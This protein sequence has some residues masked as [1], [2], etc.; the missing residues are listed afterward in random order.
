[1]ESGKTTSNWLKE[2]TGNTEGVERITLELEVAA[3]RLGSCTWLDTLKS[4]EEILV[5]DADETKFS[6]KNKSWFVREVI[7][8]TTTGL[9]S[10]VEDGTEF[11]C[12]YVEEKWPTSKGKQ[13][14]SCIT[15]RE[16]TI[17]FVIGL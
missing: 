14:S 13:P 17:L 16:I 11:D 10:T 15:S 12:V 2:R 8:L 1:M 5:D 3:S 9:I 6:D 4:R 7:R